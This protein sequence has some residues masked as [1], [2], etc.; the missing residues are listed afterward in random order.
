MNNKPGYFGKILWI[1]LTKGS[2]EEQSL[3]DEIYEQYLGGYGLGVK[4]LFDRMKPGQDPLGPQNILG[5]IPGLL[6]GTGAPFTG[7]YM[8]VGKSPLTGTWGDSNSGG[9][10][11][12]ALKKCGVDGI[13]FTGISKKRVYLLIDSQGPQLLDASEYWGKDAVET[14]ELLS[15]KHGKKVQVAAIGQA[16]ENKSLISGIVNNKGRIAARS[17][18]GAVMGSKQLKAIVLLG[19]EKIPLNDQETVKKLS[20]EYNKKINKMPGVIAAGTPKFAPMAASLFRKLRIPMMKSTAELW[21]AILKSQGTSLANAVSSESGD[22]PV[23]NWGGVGY[24]D[25]PQSRARNIGG[26]Q[27][28]K[29]KTKPYGCSAC[30]VRCG[31]ILSVPELN[32]KE[33]HRP[34]Y[35]TSCMFGTLVLNDDLLSIMEINELCNRAGIDTIS[36]GATLA[37]AVECFENDIITSND[38]GG[39]ELNWG[40][41]GSIKSMLKKM[42]NREG[43]GDILAD[44]VKKASEKIEKNSGKF[45]IHAGGQELPAH[46]PKLLNSLALSY[47][48]DPTPGRHT[49]A[50]I[51]FQDQFA[52]STKFIK[53]LKLPKKRNKNPQAKAEAQMLATAA[54]Q[55]INSLGYCEFGVYCG[56]MPVFE[57]I[58]SSTGWK[59]NI[60]DLIKT[61]L[62]IQNLRLAFTL[63]EGVNPIKTGLSNRVLGNPPQEKGPN[64][65]VTIDLDEQKKEYYTLMGWDPVTGLPHEKTLKDL[66]LDFVIKDIL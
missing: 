14:E 20:R 18:L 49:A 6:T 3:P 42:I 13:F 60:D 35:E 12:P 33:T 30:P 47:A 66:G 40:N 45:A 62:R 22:S 5:F 56:P 10:F 17:G 39:I 4:L 46:D 34:E 51:D 36:A 21:I 15:Q 53:G 43:F 1:D 16:G 65:G 52:G 27:F 63:R 54:K 44:G 26:H 25:F 9:S 28:L 19:T 55:V 32:M 59:Y 41:T 8:V 58:S 24:V 37:F 50:S 31:A 57:I 11:G 61:G 23:K 38:T 64:K 29:Y 7:R 48:A 2:I